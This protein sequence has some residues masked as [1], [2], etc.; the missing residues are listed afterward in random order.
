[1]VIDPADLQRHYASLSDEMLL[2]IDAAELSSAARKCYR[3]EFEKR[4]LAAPVD[5]AEV[6][7]RVAAS[8]EV[9]NGVKPDWIEDAACA[10]GYASYPGHDAAPDVELAREVLEAAG[11]PCHVAVFRSE[12][13]TRRQVWHEFRV[14]VPGT[15]TLKAT[16]VLNKEIFN[17]KSEAEWKAHF[18][19]L[20]D[21]ELRVLDPEVICAGLLDRAKRL[22]RVYDEEIARR[23]A[24]RQLV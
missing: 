4:G 12:P 5:E 17:A 20:S 3:R 7:E 24:A 6:F 15:L 23:G 22:K 14:M 1:M 11:I 13:D 21:D 19:E 8:V 10:C 18:E 2:A 9:D 16:S